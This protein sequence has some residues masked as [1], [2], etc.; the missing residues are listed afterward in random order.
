MVVMQKGIDDASKN[1][2]EQIQSLINDLIVIFAGGEPTGIELGDLKYIIQALGALFGLNGPF[3]MSLIE[4]ASNFFLGYVVPLP[5]FTDVIFDTIFAW[6][7]ELGLSPEFIDTLREFADA[8]TELGLD[9]GDLLN[10]IIGL[11]DIFGILP[12]GSGLGILEAIWDAIA[13]LFDGINTVALKPILNAIAD[14]TIPFIE[15]LTAAV[16]WID[17]IVDSFSDGLGDIQGILNFASVFSGIDWIASSNPLEDFV[18]WIGDLLGDFIDNAIDI[19]GKIIPIGNLTEEVQSV[20]WEGG[21]DT[22][23]TIPTG[24][25]FTWDGTEGETSPFGNAT[26]TGNSTAKAIYSNAFDVAPGHI[27]RS[28]VAVKYTSASSTGADS[29]ILEL[30][31][32]NAAGTPGTA[33]KVAGVTPTGNSSG[34]VVL[35]NDY[36]VPGSGWTKAVARIQATSSLSAGT[37]K[38]DNAS[39]SRVQ[40]ISQSWI[41]G[42]VD[43]LSSIVDWI[44]NLVDQLLESIGLPG[45]GDLLSK[46]GDLAEGL[47]DWLL[48]TQSTASQI[49]NLA[50]D[51]LNSPATVLGHL[52]DVVVE[53]AHTI[54][55]LFADADDAIGDVFDDVR[56]GWNAFW[57]GIFG[58]TGSTGKT[59]SDVQTAA[60]N[61]TTTASDAVNA[62]QTATALATYAGGRAMWESANPTIDAPILEAALGTGSTPT[63]FTASQTASAMGFVRTR[64]A[65]D[66][67]LVQ[68]IGRGN[69]MTTA[70]VHIYRMDTDTGDLTWLQTVNITPSTLPNASGFAR[71]NLPLTT[72]VHMDPGDVLGIEICVTGGTHDVAGITV[73]WATPDSSA[74]PQGAG[75]S[76]NSGTESSAPTTILDANVPYGTKIPYIGAGIPQGELTPPASTYYFTDTFNSFSSWSAVGSANWQI[77][78]GTVINHSPN[79]SFLI[80]ANS[81]YSDK[82][83]ALFTMAEVIGR[84]GIAFSENAFIRYYIH[85]NAACTN[86]VGIEFQSNGASQ[87]ATVRL[88]SLIGGVRTVRDTS[89]TTRAD[90]STGMYAIEYDPATKTYTAYS[91]AAGADP[92]SWTDSGDLVQ[93]GPDYRRAGVF[94]DF[95]SMGVLAANRAVSGVCGNFT[96]YDVA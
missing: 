69:S 29:V 68:W 89:T 93:H 45:I 81:T 35:S 55:D 63:Y 13:G 37:I 75:A 86:G 23:D 32:Y 11:F 58:T 14:W 49:F 2:I 84:N 73:A 70:K 7:E 17:Q 36:T 30:I 3:P 18:S 28:R 77:I 96:I 4:A 92:M 80:Y 25:G 9:I 47:G 15:A 48:D 1:T 91:K 34:W 46:I 52:N 39:V 44:E 59:A 78:S 79:P 22:A 31:P 20:L 71:F 85:L 74:R 54:G 12:D 42:L 5:Q 76:R 65:Q 24:F 27:L 88:I 64:V 50:D 87:P 95:D 43:D 26:T 62:A 19:I 41:D 60:S 40:K 57:D 94:S 33:I 38:F 6:A 21:F 61:V 10:S 56:T 16:D 8:I 51:L 82:V 90:G 72:P 53:G 67:S 66:K 83:K